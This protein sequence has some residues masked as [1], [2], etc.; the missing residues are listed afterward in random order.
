MWPTLVSLSFWNLYRLVLKYQAYILVSYLQHI[1]VDVFLSLYV[2]ALNIMLVFSVLS[3]DDKCWWLQVLVLHNLLV[4][5][6]YLLFSSCFNIIIALYKNIFTSY[7]GYHFCIGLVTSIFHLTLF[8]QPTHVIKRGRH[9][10]YHAL[11]FY[12]LAALIG[13]PS[14]PRNFL[15]A[16][17]LCLVFFF[18]IS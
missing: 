7:T 15:F 9:L 2:C 8:F 10:L 6:M 11:E 12:R 5:Q 13:D 16:C 4:I 17:L 3:L 14:L 18:L 1:R